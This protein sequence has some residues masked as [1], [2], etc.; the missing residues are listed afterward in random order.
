MNE[1]VAS[2][3]EHRMESTGRAGRQERRGQEAAS[4]DL[5]IGSLDCG[6]R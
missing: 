3:V 4:V 6:Q 5:T 2:D 1:E